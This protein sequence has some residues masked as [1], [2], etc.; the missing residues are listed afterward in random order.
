MELPITVFAF[1]GFTPVENPRQYR[2]TLLAR[3][4]AEGVRG[5]I[6]LATEGVNATISGPAAGIEAVVGQLYAWFPRL[7]LTSRTSHTDAQPFQR[8]KVKVKP[9]LISIGAPAATTWALRNGPSRPSRTTPPC[10]VAGRAP[11]SSPRLP[12]PN[13]FRCARSPRPAPPNSPTC[14]S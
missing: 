7:A 10:G 14:P 5:T 4:V 9:E 13:P 12:S 1:Y 2:E 3:M 6:T 8:S 11:P